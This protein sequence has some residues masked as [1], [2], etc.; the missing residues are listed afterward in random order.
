MKAKVI[1]LV[2]DSLGAIPTQFGN[3]V[4]E[5]DITAEIGQVQKTFLLRT[6]RIL[7]KVFKT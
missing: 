2:M 7:K 3:R 5:T 1:P 4:K 6:A